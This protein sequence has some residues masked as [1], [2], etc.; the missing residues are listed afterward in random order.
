LR[1]RKKTCIVESGS[2]RRALIFGLA[3][4]LVG[5]GPVPLSACALLNLKPAECATPKTQSQCDQMKMDET[6]TQLVAASDVSC[7]L[8]SRAPIQQSQQKGPGFSLAVPIAVS[9]PTSDTPRIHHLS[10]VHI[11]P[12]P[13]PPSLQPLLCT[14]LI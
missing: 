14:F 8:V 12:D 3:L 13:S 10:P 1:L 7:C 11:V 4:S 9:D 5:L 6:G 2:V